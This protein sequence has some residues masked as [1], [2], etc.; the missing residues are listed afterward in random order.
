[1]DEFSSSYGEH[2]RMSETFNMENA[3]IKKTANDAEDINTNSNKINF[4]DQNGNYI[5]DNFEDKTNDKH[6]EAN[7]KIMDYISESNSSFSMS[8]YISESS[9][10]DIDLNSFKQKN[11]FKLRTQS[12]DDLEKD[13]NKKYFGDSK[14]MKNIKA[15]ALE[16]EAIIEMS[17]SLEDDDLKRSLGELNH[18]YDKLLLYCTEYE[19]ANSGKDTREDKAGRRYRLVRDIKRVSKL[20]RD[21]LAS[22]VETYKNIYKHKKQLPNWQEIIQIARAEM[23]LDDRDKKNI[24][25]READNAK[26]LDSIVA[27]S[28]LADYLGASNIFLQRKY[29][30]NGGLCMKYE[31]EG[32]YDGFLEQIYAVNL[33]RLNNDASIVMYTD[34]AL[35]KLQTIRVMEAILGFRF[36]DS[37]IKLKYNS[38]EKNNI[39]EKVVIEDIIVNLW[40]NDYSIENMK[41]IDENSG[42]IIDRTLANS[43]QALDEDLMGRLFADVMTPDQ[44]KILKKNIKKMK[45]RLT[46]KDTRILEDEEWIGE[47]SEALYQEGLAYEAN[48]EAALKSLPKKSRFNEHATDI[49]LRLYGNR[50]KYTKGRIDK[51]EIAG[52]KEGPV[53]IAD[54][55]KMEIYSRY[56]ARELASINASNP[57]KNPIPEEREK[58][59]RVN[60]KYIKIAAEADGRNLT[61]AR[62]AY[63]L[64]NRKTKGVKFTNEDP[65]GIKLIF[66]HVPE[67]SD[68]VQGAA[69]NRELMS[70]L[71]TIVARDPEY[72]MNMFE[73][74]G[75]YVLVK[76]PKKTVAVSKNVVMV[77]KGNKKMPYY[78]NGAYWV[79]LFEKAYAAL[80]DGVPTKRV[81]KLCEM[82]YREKNEDFS[83]FNMEFSLDDEL[84]DSVERTAGGDVDTIFKNITGKKYSKAELDIITAGNMKKA[85]SNMWKLAKAGDPNDS[86]FEAFDR[87]ERYLETKLKSALEKEIKRRHLRAYENKSGGTSK[88]FYRSVTIEGIR[89]ILLDI[90]NWNFEPGD[91][92]YRMLYMEVKK[93]FF[94]S[95]KGE[96][97]VSGE[98]Y[99]EEYFMKLISKLADK[100]ANACDRDRNGFEHDSHIKTGIYS[101][102]ARRIASFLE[103]AVKKG[104]VTAT[105]KSFMKKPGK[106]INAEMAS[107]G[108]VE[109]NTYIVT[110]YTEDSKSGNLVV[111][112]L[113]PSGLE[114]SKYH[115][116]TDKSKKNLQIKSISRQSEDGSFTLELNDFIRFFG[117]ITLPKEVMKDQEVK[118]LYNAIN[119]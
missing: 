86:K 46:K 36:N 7:V 89:D 3:K 55:K 104:T 48:V 113:N 45:A 58:I 15:A 117:E 68:I 75:E 40:N 18:A 31:S 11:G 44:K 109:G 66:E 88:S 78:S 80:C 53:K 29:V 2:S 81:E 52:A 116:F 41:P 14:R 60:A 71:A 59:K 96:F 63:K 1:M 8:D 19:N 103:E 54:S 65:N 92:N 42:V 73:N 97:I 35:K 119:R 82:Y 67:P 115:R 114:V 87:I 84:D 105:A 21:N 17:V 9:Q 90:K 64:D 23:V 76:F 25:Y 70:V 85:Y 101:G 107:E 12:L 4:I 100:L 118:T 93:E 24:V 22:A 30:N 56:E 39:T 108:I 61:F 47:G 20:E 57:G 13:D 33:L 91:T 38:K 26:D 94:T 6:T 77:Q 74:R 49:L 79:A 62:L 112:L 10:S 102:R 27:A 32:H 16:V 43:I 98:S 69:D 99:T 5:L 110:G 37:D 83:A 95:K 50:I 51:V 72:I 28:R 111:T 106:G 34:V